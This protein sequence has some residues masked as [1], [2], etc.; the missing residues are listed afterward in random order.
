MVIGR[1]RTMFQKWRFRA[2]FDGLGEVFFGKIGPL[3][4]S[5]EVVKYNDG[6]A[7]IPHKELGMMEFPA[8]T[9]ERGVTED[10]ALYQWALDAS[11][12][13]SDRGVNPADYKRNGSVFQLDRAGNI[14]KSYRIYAAM[15]TKFTAGDWDNSANE[16]NIEIL[17][18]EYDYFEVESSSI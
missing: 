11:N 3:E 4:F 8:L 9:C 13:A 5:S 2:E 17:E 14:V 10:D 18:L 7:M 12:A 6:G 1:Q 15:P 16:V